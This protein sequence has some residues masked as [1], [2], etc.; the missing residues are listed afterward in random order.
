VPAG[1]AWHLTKLLTPSPKRLGS[2]LSVPIPANKAL[3]MIALAMPLQ[4]AQP[5]VKVLDQQSQHR[6][7]GART[8]TIAMQKMQQRL[9]TGP[10][11][12]TTQGKSGAHCMRPG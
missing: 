5:E 3:A 12:P 1:Q 8:K 6:L 7:I 11:V 10:S 2:R 4:V 9:A